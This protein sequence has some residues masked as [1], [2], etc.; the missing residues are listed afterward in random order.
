MTDRRCK[1]L[2]LLVDMVL[3][4]GLDHGE[5]GQDLL[6]RIAY[7]DDDRRFAFISLSLDFYSDKLVILAVDCASAG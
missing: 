3:F 1:A 7:E 6:G 2:C 4:L 5:L